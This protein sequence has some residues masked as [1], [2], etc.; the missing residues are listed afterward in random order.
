[1]DHTISSGRRNLLLAALALTGTAVHPAA[2]RAVKRLA[3]VMPPWD[4]EEKADYARAFEPLGYRLGANL[5]ITWLEFPV[6]SRW[7]DVVPPLAAEAVRLRPDCIRTQG[8][9]FTRFVQE[10]TR[11]IPIVTSINEGDPVALGFAKS[12]ARP[13]GNV[14]GLHGGFAEVNTKRIEFLRRLVPGLTCVGWIAFRPQLEWFGT[15]E[16]AAR[17]FGVRVRPIVADS[18][19][20]GPRFESAKREIA[21]L[22][23]EGCL[24]AHFHS[25][26]PELIE[27]VTASALEH[28]IAISYSGDV[29]TVSRDGIMFMYHATPAAKGYEAPRRTV[30]M[31]ARIFRGERP[32]NMPFEGPMGY[33]LVFNQRTA[34]RIGVTIPPD[35][36]TMANKII[37]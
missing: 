31:I 32:E 13:G 1:M 2:D 10:A 25:G 20:D 18:A 34:R 3:V 14:T 26:M 15:F 36:V 16:N 28:R 27:A 6:R 24:A 5:E 7:N 4:P 37:R 12:L 9:N 30:S 22:R 21:K 19:A 35:I 29:A 8:A 33:E 23:G 17:D 11:T